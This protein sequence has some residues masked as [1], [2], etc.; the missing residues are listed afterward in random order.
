MRLWNNLF[1]G[2]KTSLSLALKVEKFLRNAGSNGEI[3][4]W[5]TAYDDGFIWSL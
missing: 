3:K 5:I 2:L 4:L 1:R